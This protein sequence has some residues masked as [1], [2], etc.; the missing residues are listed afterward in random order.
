MNEN[1]KGKEKEKEM[2]IEKE[3][4]NGFELFDNHSSVPL[5]S[6][7]RFYALI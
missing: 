1:D 4:E 6:L 3:K 2:E 7:L 5:V